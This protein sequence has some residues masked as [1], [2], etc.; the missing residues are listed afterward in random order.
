MLTLYKWKTIKGLGDKM[1]KS[2]DWKLVK[3]S[4]WFDGTIQ[5]YD[6]GSR[7]DYVAWHKETNMFL[8]WIR[9]NQVD[10]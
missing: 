8:G 1:E 2:E 5:Y 3:E 10:G 4:P 6:V 9:K 7:V